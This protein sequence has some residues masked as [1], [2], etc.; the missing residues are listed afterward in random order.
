[1]RKNFLTDYSAKKENTYLFDVKHARIIIKRSPQPL[2]RNDPA[3]SRLACKPSA[4][5]PCRTDTENRI[6]STC[7]FHQ[8]HPS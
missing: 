7:N 4:N 2:G 5:R 1:M 3:A 6:H 8:N